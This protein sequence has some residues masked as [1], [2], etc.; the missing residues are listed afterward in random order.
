M[1]YANF[2]KVFESF[3]IVLYFLSVSIIKIKT[4]FSSN[5]AY[6]GTFCIQN[7]QFFETLLV[8]EIIF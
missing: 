6:F 7:W 2:A 5:N 4:L 8:F 1:K 3:F